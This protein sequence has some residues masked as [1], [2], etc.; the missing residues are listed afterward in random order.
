M[1]I[2]INTIP[3]ISPLTGTGKYIYQVAK[4]LKE[5]A[6][7]H[8]YSYFYGYYSSHLI[9]PGESPEILYRVKKTIRKIPFLRAAARNLKNFSNYFSSR[10][11]DLY[12]EPNFIPL[13]IR[14]RHIVVTIPDF[15]FAIFP[16]WHTRETV[17][18]FRKHFW[19]KIKMADRVIVISDFIKNEAI[20]RFGFP[21]DLL[22]TIHLGFDQDVFRVYT[23]QDLIPV[24]NQYRLPENFILFVGSIEPRK[25]LKNL[26]YA[27]MNLEESFRKEFKLVLV[28][29]KGWENDELM[30]MLKN[31]KSDVLYIGYVP[32]NELGKFYNLARVLVYPTLYEGFGLPAL[33]AMACGCPVIASNV[34]S[35]PEI[36]GQAGYYINPYEVKSITEGIDKVLKDD[37]LR[38]SLIGKGL[39]RCKQFSWEKSARDHLKVFEEVMR[40]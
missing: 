32:E 30:K 1:K 19:K 10:N 7:I 18:Y 31:L 23:P 22:T 11:F 33:E 17:R 35:L 15:S 40:N 36:C 20:H 25:N 27:Y 38:N 14:A 4:A 39:E 28:G 6:W 24:K 29:F 37:D 13:N 16:H 3:L 5:T 21:E 9:S 8:E 26:L 12:F 2:A 34:A